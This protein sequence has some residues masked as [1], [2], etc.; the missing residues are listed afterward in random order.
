MRRDVCLV[1]LMAQVVGGAMK[2]DMV[3][4]ILNDDRPPR[5]SILET[6]A[7]A[8]QIPGDPLVRSD[9]AQPS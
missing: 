7:G 9:P 4:R 8:A 2:K 5:T 6:P 1:E 3:E